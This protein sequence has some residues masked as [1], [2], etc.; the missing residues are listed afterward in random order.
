MQIYLQKKRDRTVG[1]KIIPKYRALLF[2]IVPGTWKSA[3]PLCKNGHNIM[4]VKKKKYVVCKKRKFG[5][6]RVSPA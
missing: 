3:C 6:K 1:N 4:L 5:D 2:L